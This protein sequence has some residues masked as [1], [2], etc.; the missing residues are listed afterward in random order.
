MK[1]VVETNY[2]VES[3]GYDDLIPERTAVTGLV[4]VEMTAGRAQRGDSG[5]PVF[6]GTGLFCGTL[7]T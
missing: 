3:L 6:T 1:K 4:K 7:S 5:G 2:Y